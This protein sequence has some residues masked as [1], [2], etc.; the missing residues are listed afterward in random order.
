MNGYF[1]DKTDA[2]YRD[3]LLRLLPDGAAWDKGE[4]SGLYQAAY[5]FGGVLSRVHNRILDAIQ[6]EGDPRTADETLEAW[7][8]SWGLPDPCATA[9]TTD[10]ARRAAL[11]ARVVDT[12]GLTIND[13]VEVAAALG[14]VV[15]VTPV[16]QVYFRVG[17]S[18]ISDELWSWADADKLLIT[19]DTAG[20]LVSTDLFECAIKRLIAH[21]TWEFTYTP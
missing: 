20:A 3:V 1:P 18:E 16:Y 8:E 14:Y 17:I 9:P 2:D 10:A 15:T 7:E 5:A 19:A 12:G 6:T 4:G 21:A 11:H 13:I